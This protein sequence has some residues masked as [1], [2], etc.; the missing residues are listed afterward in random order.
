[1]IYI[2]I[3]LIIILIWCWNLLCNH[4]KFKKIQYK[5]I[6]PYCKTG[7]LIL[8]HGLDNYNSIFIG[9]YYTHMGIIYRE[10]PTSR[11]YLFEAWNPKHEVMYPKE[12]KHGMA[13]T[14]L[15]NRIESY[16]GY[17]FYK[18][19]KYPIDNFKNEIF[20]EFIYWAMNNMKYNTKVISNGLN[21]LLF[22][23]C[24]RLGTNCGEIVYLSLIKL[25]LLNLDRF[26]ENRKHHLLWVSN[27]TKTD[28]DN[29]YLPIIYIWQNYFHIIPNKN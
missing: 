17:I 11:P 26:Y 5:E 10:T 25:G 16:R 21:K 29:C 19:L 13:F 12:I 3:L 2:I 7:D 27:L 20:Y 4:P 28:N 14:D 6:E 24:L 22:N 23:D 1:M 8:F 9:C 15:E 18:P